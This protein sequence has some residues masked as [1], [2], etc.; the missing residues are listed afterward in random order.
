MPHGKGICKCHSNLEGRKI[1]AKH[2]P[3]ICKCEKHQTRNSLYRQDFR[4]IY[5]DGPYICGE[6]KMGCGELVSFGEAVIDHVDEDRKNNDPSNWQAMHKLC[7]DRKS[8]L[9]RGVTNSI[10]AFAMNDHAN[11]STEARSARVK[12]QWSKRISQ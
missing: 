2:G 3:G 8:G 5:G 1:Q 10:N 6:R 12:E 9:C 4:E 7:H 11:N